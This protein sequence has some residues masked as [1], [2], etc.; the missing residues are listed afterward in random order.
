MYEPDRTLTSGGPW[1]SGQA[2]GVRLF[3][4]LLTLVN[5][6]LRD[7]QFKTAQTGKT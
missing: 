2:Y 6:V 4:D 5:A 1:S 7:K 3:A